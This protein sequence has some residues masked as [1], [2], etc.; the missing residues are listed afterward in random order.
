MSTLDNFFALIKEIEDLGEYSIEEADYIRD[1]ISKVPIDKQ[2]STEFYINILDLYEECLAE[3][4][5]GEGVEDLKQKNR[6]KIEK[7]VESGDLFST[8]LIDYVRDENEKEIKLMKGSDI[9]TKGIANCKRCH[10]DNLVINSKQTRGGDE[11]ETI[12]YYCLDC[13]HKWKES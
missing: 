11:G 2:N 5:R 10:L 3:E 6:E 8:P 1:V 4:K 12:F 13:G 9:G 7:Y